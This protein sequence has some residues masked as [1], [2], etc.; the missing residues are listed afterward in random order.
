MID[1][2]LV[3]AWKRRLQVHPNSGVGMS[4]D[5]YRERLKPAR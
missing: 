4:A 5:E 3:S 1:D 2:Q